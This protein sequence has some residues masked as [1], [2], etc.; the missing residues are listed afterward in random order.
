MNSRNVS[1]WKFTRSFESRNDPPSHSLQKSNRIDRRI[2]ISRKK[3]KFKPIEKP[4]SRFPFA[5][6]NFLSTAS[7]VWNF[8]IAQR[9]TWKIV[10]LRIDRSR[11][12]DLTD[13]DRWRVKFRNWSP[14][15][16]AKDE[17]E[18]IVRSIDNGFRLSASSR[19]RITL[20]CLICPAI[21]QPVDVWFDG[22]SRD[23]RS[24]A[25]I[26]ARFPSIKEWYPCGEEESL[27]VGT[28]AKLRGISAL[29]SGDAIPRNVTILRKK[30]CNIVLEIIARFVEKNCDRWKEEERSL[31]GFFVK[32]SFQ[33]LFLGKFWK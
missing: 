12:N 19:P 23:T 4:L 9:R 7:T 14:S 31:T 10:S 21:R 20:S 16:Q 5:R 17:D 24:S 29:R 33:A 15:V 11:K 30:L 28:G 2:S 13:G 18:K 3:K 26:N 8:R 32:D 25:T 1:I 27:R 6:K 22:L